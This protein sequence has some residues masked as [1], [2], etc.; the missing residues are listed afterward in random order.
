MVACT[1]NATQHPG[2]A[3]LVNGLLEAG[4]KTVVVAL[5]LPYDLAAYPGVATYICTYSLQPPSI[6]ALADALWG[7][8]P[9]EGRLPVT[10]AGER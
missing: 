10:V 9:F 2:Q 1:I 4:S 5:R 3:A 7:H 6:E 8:I